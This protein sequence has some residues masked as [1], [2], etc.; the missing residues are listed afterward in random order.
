[1]PLYCEAIK[2]LCK[3]WSIRVRTLILR[4]ANMATLFMPFY[5]NV[6]IRSFKCSFIMAP[7]MVNRG[8]GKRLYLK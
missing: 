4:A 1:M 2:R 8:D 7:F 5:D 6:I 3:F